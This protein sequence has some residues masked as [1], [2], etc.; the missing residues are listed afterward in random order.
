LDTTV[1]LFLRLLGEVQCLKIKNTKRG[2]IAPFDIF[3][4]PE[5]VF[6]VVHIP[7]RQTCYLYNLEQYYIG[8]DEPQ[9]L[10]EVQWLGEGVQKE[11]KSMGLE[12]TKFTSPVAIYEEKTS[13]QGSPSYHIGLRGDCG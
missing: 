13:P 3:Y 6:S 1:S 2:H 4:V 7:T 12:P 8:Y 11:L 9:E 10:I 5:K